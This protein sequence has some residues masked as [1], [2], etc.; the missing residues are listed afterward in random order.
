[1]T[2]ITFR[3]PDTFDFAP[4]YSWFDLRGRIYNPPPL[5]PSNDTETVSLY[6]VAYGDVTGDSQ[7]EAIVI[8]TQSIRGTAIPHFVYVFTMVEGHP[9]VISS[10]PTGDR[11][12]GGLSDVRAEA[13]KLVIELN[14]R[15]SRIDGAFHDDGQG[16][17]CPV[18]VTR[19]RYTWTKDGFKPVG[20]EEIFPK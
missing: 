10:F 11:A 2:S 8:L 3:Y 16:A 17:C 6:S 13:G 7:E 4:G 18:L 19:M 12:E 9:K 20:N 5:E 1:M 15:G 14:G